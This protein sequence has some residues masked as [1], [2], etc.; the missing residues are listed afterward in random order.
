MTDLVAVPT[1]VALLQMQMSMAHHWLEGT[2]KQVTPAVALWRPSGRP[3]NIGSQYAHVAL[4]ED[5]FIQ[6][7]LRHETP[8]MAGAYAGKVGL[9]EIPPIGGSWDKWSQGVQ[10]DLDKLRAYA[11]GV[12]GATE[13]YLSS[14]GD[15]TL[16]ESVDVSD[17]GLGV[18]TV[19][20]LL[21]MLLA[22]VHNHCGE[23]A[24]IKGL[25]G[26]KGYPA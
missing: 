20:F 19:A 14:I 18:R 2:M 25:Q 16:G 24:A 10:V 12:Y 11:H 3:G 22:N 23:I 21:A 4:T 7:A 5:Y 6:V 8:L 13:D 1:Q 9:S 17:A 26:L 15:E